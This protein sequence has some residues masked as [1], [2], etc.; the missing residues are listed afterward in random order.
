MILGIIG[1]EDHAIKIHLNML[2][3]ILILMMG[4]AGCGSP[5]VR[6]VETQVEPVQPAAT[7]AAPTEPPPTQ[8]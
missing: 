3:F 2:M 6:P 5:A 4:L 1:K 7:E 8:P